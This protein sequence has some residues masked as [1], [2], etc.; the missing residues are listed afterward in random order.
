MMCSGLTTIDAGSLISTLTEAV[1][2][3]PIALSGRCRLRMYFGD[4]S[5]AVLMASSEIVTE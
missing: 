1:S 2:S 5:S 3:Q 4:I